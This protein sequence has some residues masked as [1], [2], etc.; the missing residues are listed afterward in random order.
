MIAY[1]LIEQLVGSNVW[2]DYT[3]GSVTLGLI[4]SF[5]NNNSLELFY[6]NG[7]YF[8]KVGGDNYCL[9]VLNPIT[10]IV[11]DIFSFNG[12]L[13]TIPCYHDEISDNAIMYALG[14]NSE[15]IESICNS[16]IKISN[17]HLYF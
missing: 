11:R 8:L 9:L 2:Q 5:M 4:Q 1:S 10:C 7:Y 12:L 13:G 14:N 3:I 6:E 17:L 15:D 16:S